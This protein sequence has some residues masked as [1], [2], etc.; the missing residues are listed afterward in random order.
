MSHLGGRVRWLFANHGHPAT[1]L[2]CI[3]AS[4][5]SAVAGATRVPIQLNGLDD[6]NRGPRLAAKWRVTHSRITRG[7]DVLAL[8]DSD[9]KTPTFLLHQQHAHTIHSRAGLRAMQRNAPLPG[10]SA[11]EEL[12]EES[13]RRGGGSRARRLVAVAPCGLHRSVLFL[14][15]FGCA[16]GT[17]PTR[18]GNADQ[19]TTC[20]TEAATL[21]G[22]MAGMTRFEFFKQLGNV[23][24]SASLACI[25][26]Q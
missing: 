25:Q 18:N 17:R 2:G 12:G 6:H 19:D 20:L 11:A 14:S 7:F 21:S 23:S 26:C 1:H 9:L 13:C 3:T 24:R 16:M 10:R 22:M 4:T 15:R 5:R 8:S